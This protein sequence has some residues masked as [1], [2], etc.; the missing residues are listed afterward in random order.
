MFFQTKAILKSCPIMKIHL[1]FNN[2]CPIYHYTWKLYVMDVFSNIEILVVVF[3]IGTFLVVQ[4]LVASFVIGKVLVPK[5]S[6]INYKWGFFLS[7]CWKID[8]KDFKNFSS[9]PQ[10]VANFILCDEFLIFE[11]H[12]LWYLVPFNECLIDT[13]W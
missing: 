12:N 2:C 5:V 3:A 10:L 7:I 11:C 1:L 13:C 9:L 4:F 6:C 8:S